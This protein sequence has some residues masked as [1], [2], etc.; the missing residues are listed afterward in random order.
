MTIYHMHIACWIPKATNKH[1]HTL[2]RCNM[3]CFSIATMLTWMHLNVALYV[4]CLSCACLVIK[5]F[6]LGLPSVHTDD[7]LKWILISSKPDTHSHH[8]LFNLNPCFLYSVNN[9]KPCVLASAKILRYWTKF[10]N[11]VFWHQY[12]NFSEVQTVG[13]LMLNRN[14]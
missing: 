5:C 8:K 9:I 3:H 12:C 1:T 13:S 14:M 4:Y 2:R 6:S 11:E 10:N 7:S